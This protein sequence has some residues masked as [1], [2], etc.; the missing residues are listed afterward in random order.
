VDRCD[1]KKSDD[2]RLLPVW[3]YAIVMRRVSDA[4]DKSATGTVFSGSKSAP[5]FTH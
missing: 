3:L 5:L 4:P 1:A 2:R